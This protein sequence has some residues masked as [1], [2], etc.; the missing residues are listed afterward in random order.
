MQGD[1]KLTPEPYETVRRKGSFAIDAAV[2]S[3]LFVLDQF[4][5]NII[6]R[7]KPNHLV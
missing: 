6:F 1:Q 4:G 5:F 3:F 2:H 7:L